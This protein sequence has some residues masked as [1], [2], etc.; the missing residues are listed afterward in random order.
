MKKN[1]FF[2]ITY[3]IFSYLYFLITKKSFSGTNNALINVYSIDNGIFKERLHRFISIRLQNYH[4]KA[5]DVSQPVKNL[6]DYGY[7]VF[8]NKLEKKTV[9][10]LYNLGYNLK[11]NDG[12]KITYFDPKNLSAVRYNFDK[13]DLINNCYV[14][15]LIMDDFLIETVRQYF[16]SQPIFDLPAMWW[17]TSYQKIASSEAAQ[18]YH[19]DMERAK[20]LKIFF[21][22]TDVDD[23]N[24]P[25]YYIRGSHKINSKPKSLLSRGY[26]RITD[27][28][29]SKFYDPIDF[30]II[31]GKKGT[32]FVGDTLCWHK[33]KNLIKN[34][35]LVLELNYTSSLFGYNDKEDMIIKNATK[36]FKLFCS[37]NPNY[38]KKI[39]FE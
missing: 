19:Y 15:D 3:I 18:L 11:C 30:R 5:I 31:K 14:Q 9:S 26:E 1:Y 28:E 23:N 12:K 39:K 36:K 24:G 8:N 32:F 34:N 27:E 13:Q 4:N 37:K 38:S 17:S 21:Y 25:H 29:I 2:N 7:H 20:W 16:Q 22:L 10:E 6:N 33:G 35:R